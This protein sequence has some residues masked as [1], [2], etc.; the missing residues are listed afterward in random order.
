MGNKQWALV[1]ELLKLPGVN[2]NASPDEGADKGKTVLAILAEAGQWELVF[3]VLESRA[4]AEILDD[5]ITKPYQEN[6]DSI[7]AMA[8]REFEPTIRE[9]CLFDLWVRDLLK[10][11][12]QMLNQEELEQRLMAQLDTIMNP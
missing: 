4:A 9:R 10:G 12:P 1:S 6:K 11:P 2:V 7:L 5:S 3:F 8:F